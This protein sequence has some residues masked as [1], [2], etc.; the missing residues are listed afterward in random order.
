LWGSIRK[1][2]RCYT[3]CYNTNWYVIFSSSNDII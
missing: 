1:T 3:K 2:S